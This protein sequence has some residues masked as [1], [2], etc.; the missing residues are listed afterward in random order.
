MPTTPDWQ[1]LRRL[2]SAESAE[3][4]AAYKD[5]ENMASLV[6]RFGIN[7][8]TVH[9]HLDKAGIVR[10]VLAPILSDIQIEQ[11]AKL[12]AMGLSTIAVGAEFGV[13]G[14]T[15]A[16]HLKRA[17]HQLRQRRGWLGSNV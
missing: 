11:A 14:T 15:I 12:Y 16:T 5:G 1:P 7:R 3:L 4:V 10:R 17:G 9:E 6:N 2:T 13:N 8:C